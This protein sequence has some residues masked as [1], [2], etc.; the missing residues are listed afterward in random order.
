M[1]I[2]VSFVLVSS[3]FTSD[4]HFEKIKGGLRTMVYA[5][6]PSYLKA[7]AGGYIEPRRD[8]MGNKR[9]PF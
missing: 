2:S 5:C 7:D 8:N 3:C 1:F 6:S 4:G 9:A